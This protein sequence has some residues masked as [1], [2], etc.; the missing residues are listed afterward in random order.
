MTEKKSDKPL[1]KYKA[2]GNFR[3]CIKIIMDMIEFRKLAEKTQVILSLSGPDV[4]TRLT[5]TIEVAKIARDLCYALGLNEDLAEAIALAHDIGHTPFGHVGERTLKEIMCGCE[6]FNG[7]IKLNIEEAGFKHNLNSFMIL[8]QHI[9][10][11]EVKVSEDNKK[12]FS[13]ILWGVTMHSNPSYAKPHEIYDHDIL[14][15]CKQCDKV[16]M[17]NYSGADKQ[18]KYNQKYIDYE[19]KKASEKKICKPWFCSSIKNIKN[20]KFTYCEE[21]C[22]FALLWKQKLKNNKVYIEFKYLFDH[23]FPNTYYADHFYK[24]FI[25]DF[26]FDYDFITL[27]ALIV[28]QADEIAQRK[29]DI[30]DGI[31]KKLITKTEVLKKINKAVNKLNQSKENKIQ[32][33]KIKSNNIGDGIRDLYHKILC[34][35]IKS[36]FIELK[37]EFESKSID[38]YIFLDVINIINGVPD[39]ITKEVELFEK[40]KKNDYDKQVATNITF[41][42]SKLNISVSKDD[43]KNLYYILLDYLDEKI[44]LNKSIDQY[45]KSLYNLLFKESPTK[46]KLPQITNNNILYEKLENELKKRYGDKY[47]DMKSKLRLI[48]DLSTRD[49]D[50]MSLLVKNK[51]GIITTKTLSSLLTEVKNKENFNFS[52]FKKRLKFKAHQIFS[53]RFEIEQMEKYSVLDDEK[54]YFKNLILNSGIVEK[55]DSKSSFFI[56]KLFESYFTDPHQLPDIQLK[57]SLNNFSKIKNLKKEINLKTNKLISSLEKKLFDYPIDKNDITNK[58]YDKNN[59]KIPNEVKAVLNSKKDLLTYINAKTAIKS[60]NARNIINNPI[61]KTLPTWQKCLMRAICDHIAGMT[62]REAIVEYE[63]LYGG[64]M[65][66]I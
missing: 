58:N 48:E 51:I 54:K 22:Y 19:E 36:N 33:L 45:L 6:D 7:L 30:E 11:P 5:H 41:I 47:Y 27:E 29:Q 8:K 55:N 61:L 23:P 34:H 4:R 50:R 18:C 65:E 44:K 56:K 52:N 53:H 39:W 38:Y 28:A 49:F 15:N 37:S 62:D 24:Y 40:L 46:N 57:K 12:A 21:M 26:N 20:W 35:E 43:E 25:E 14:V 17:C 42:K 64:V 2:E 10:N 31:E 1:E 3:E 13:Y 16:F 59:P 32:Y 9:E 60:D 66:I 63:M